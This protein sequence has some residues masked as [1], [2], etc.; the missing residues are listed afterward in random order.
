MRRRVLVAAAA[1]AV[2]LSGGGLAAA[3]TGCRTVSAPWCA[4]GAATP[5][6]SAHGPVQ[7]DGTTASAAFRLGHRTVRQFRYTDRHEL[8]YTFTLA[9]GRPEPV[10]VVG[11]GDAGPPAT[12]LRV[13][14]L[15]RAGTSA[16]RFPVPASGEAT[17]RLVLDM[18]ACEHVSSRAGSFLSAVIVRGRTDGKP[19][20]DV[21]RLPEELHTGSPREAFC[22]RATSTSRSPG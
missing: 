15:E 11:V 20:A 3:D 8:G 5:G 9:N 2:A 16:T 13:D 12:L 18:T 17:V 22:P 10:T 6:M 7:V 19:T 14:R 21:V 1:T 4:D